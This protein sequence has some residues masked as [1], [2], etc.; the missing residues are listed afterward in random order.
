[1]NPRFCFFLA[2]IMISINLAGVDAYQHGDM[3]SQKRSSVSS[4]EH[5]F[6][7]IPA[8]AVHIPD[9]SYVGISSPRP[10]IEEARQQALG[11]AIGQILQSMGA[12]YHLS[13]ESVLSG[14]FH[15]SKYELKE[16]LSYTAKWLLNSVQQ[17]IRQYAFQ[18]T[19][20]GHVCFVLVRMTPLELEKLKRLTIGAKVSAR[21]IGTKGGQV[22]VEVSESNGVGVTVTEYRLTAAIKHHHAR[23]ITL[24][25]W[26]VPETDSI[27]HEGALPNKISLKDSSGRTTIP[28]SNVTDRLKSILMGSKE[29]FSIT[30]MGYDELGRP[31]SVSVKI[32]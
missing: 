30:L 7:D 28:V 10:S 31:V 3:N 15:S 4:S 8:W 32:P 13:H 16:R 9:H 24:F 1:M 20:N 26:K 14:D 19:D 23:L 2:L 17:N 25:L 22:S 5:S 12:D 21:L 6:P 18:H 29:D 27:T 11:S